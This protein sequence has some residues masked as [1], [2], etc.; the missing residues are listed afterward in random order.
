MEALTALPILAH[1]GG[2]DEMLL[3]AGP[4]VV[5]AGLLWVANRRVQRQLSEQGAPPDTD[6]E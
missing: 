6:V 4:L 2:W 5:I 3:V 1:Q